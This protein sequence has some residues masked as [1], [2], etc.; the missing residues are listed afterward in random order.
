MSIDQLELNSTG[1][2]LSKDK[3]SSWLQ[4][5]SGGRVSVDNPLPEEINIED[6]SKAL[7][8]LCRYNGHC[9]DFYSVAQ[10]CVLG[11]KFALENFGKEAAKEFLLHDATE[12]FVGDMIRPVKALNPWF[13]DTEDL[14]WKAI[15][16]K[17]GLPL[18]HS[19]SCHYIDN[20]MLVWEKRDLLPK[21]EEW[22]NLP[23]IEGFNLP[24]MK[25]WTWNRSE[26]EFNKLYEKLFA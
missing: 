25:C 2:F 21:S 17:F 26:K 3:K 20:V 1:V 7:S 22:P 11:A 23:N 8:K 12:A 19:Q 5:G 14:F 18:Q 16:V 10:H 15:A 13:Q 9:E 6:I 24:V 4:T